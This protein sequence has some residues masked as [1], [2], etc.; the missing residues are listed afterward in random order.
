M[1]E[2]ESAEVA[3]RFGDPNLV[4]G[5]FEAGDGDVQI[6]FGLYVIAPE[7]QQVAQSSVGPADQVPV[8]Q[9]FGVVQARAVFAFRFLPLADQFMDGAFSKGQFDD[10]FVFGGGVLQDQFFVELERLPVLEVAL[11]ITRGLF[12]IMVGFGIL[13]GF[14]IVEGEVDVAL[15]RFGV[16]FFDGLGNGPAQFAQAGAQ[17]RMS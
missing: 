1:P 3:I 10:F 11:G 16:Q 7:H 17:C 4:V 9:D 2:K 8:V 5:Q 13:F 15:F 14:F 12:Q 6:L